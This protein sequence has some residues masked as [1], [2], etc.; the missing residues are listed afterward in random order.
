MWSNFWNDLNSEQ[1]WRFPEIAPWQIHRTLGAQVADSSELVRAE[2]MWWRRPRAI[3]GGGAFGYILAIAISIM[4]FLI[5]DIGV[6]LG[7]IWLLS[8]FLLIAFDAVRKIRWRRDYERSVYR[9]IRTMEGRES[10]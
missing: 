4:L 6:F 1:A 10:M 2:W 5:P 7:A 8:C 3:L 9:M